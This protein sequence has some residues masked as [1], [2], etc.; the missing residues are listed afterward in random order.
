MLK[1]LLKKQLTEVFKSYFYDAKKNRMRSKAAIAAWIIFFVVIMVVLLGGI[2]TYLALN[3]CGSLCEAGMGWMYFLLMGNIAVM[4]GGFGSVFNTYA[5]LYLAGDNDLLLSLPIPVNMIIAA[6]L[7]NVYL[8][9]TMYSATVLIPALVVYWVTVGLTAARV[10]CGIALFLIVTG[11]VLLLSCVLGWVVSRISLKLKNK[12]FVT[13]L[14][15]LLF[16]AAYYFFYFK[17][18]D[19]IKDVIM[20]AVLYGEKIKGAAYILYLFGRIG[21]GC[22]EAAAGFLAGTAL[23]LLLIWKF[24][25]RSFMTV[26]ASGGSVNKKR[27]VEKPAKERSAFTALLAK[28][29]GRFISSANFML[30]CG[31]GVLLLL[32]SGIAL[33]IKGREICGIIGEVFS[34]YPD[35]TAVLLCTILC[36]VSDMND[37]CV[38][39]V[40]LEGKSLWIPKSLPVEAKTV[41]RAKASVQL[42]LTCIPM[43][44][45]A[46]CAA[47]I[48]ETEPLVRILIVVMPVIYSFF[49]AMFGS[50]LGVRMPLLTW[51]DELAPIKQSGAIMI[52][53]FGNW[54]IMAA[55]GI[56]YFL[57]GYKIGAA[58]YLAICAVLFA[59]AGLLLLRWLDTK[60]CR[61]FDEL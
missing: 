50:F 59:A 31:L 37:M 32:V 60:G 9:G 56:L 20:N 54:G 53:L 13:V 2:F 18:S 49:S 3:M 24:M 52:I 25:S 27:Y 33:L 22:W 39:L 28:E 57:A 55:F 4:L 34:R 26:A 36:L 16:I 51:T 21:E 10:I 47:V 23:L 15:S 12:S 61:I 43:L 17:A 41:L 1:V 14:L 48:L 44:Y 29:F 7:M 45:A 6:R 35:S 40:S 42:I 30:N 8:M 58:A 19:L 11:T 46:V 38:P 5:G